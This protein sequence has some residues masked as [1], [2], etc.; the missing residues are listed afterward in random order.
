MT[1]DPK[2]P[3]PEEADNVPEEEGNDSKIGVPEEV[4]PDGE[5]DE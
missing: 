4:K 5:T 3:L 2:L 1:D